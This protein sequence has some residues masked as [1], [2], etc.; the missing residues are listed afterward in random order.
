MSKVS[1]YNREHGTE[2]RVFVSEEDVFNSFI[3]SQLEGNEK[4]SILSHIAKIL[5]KENKL[6]N[7]D[8]IE[9]EKLKRR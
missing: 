8:K 7:F 9:I 5:Y 4:K 6:E 1:F 3:I 2:Y